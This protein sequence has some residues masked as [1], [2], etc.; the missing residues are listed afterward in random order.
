MRARF[1]LD[2]EAAIPGDDAWRGKLDSDASP[3]RYHP[4]R[5]R[6]RC[7]PSYPGYTPGWGWQG[8]VP[9][10]RWDS[11]TLPGVE[12]PYGSRYRAYGEWRYRGA[13]PAAPLGPETQAVPRVV[14]DDPAT[15]Y[16]GPW[17]WEIDKDTPEDEKP[18]GDAGIR[19]TPEQAPEE[20]RP[21]HKA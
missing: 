21:D 18:K 13:V 15:E 16:K 20:L 5:N 9:G 12:A 11:P 14:P 7:T 3:W 10:R 6:L 1:G 8:Y 4:R 19:V 17:P 2:A